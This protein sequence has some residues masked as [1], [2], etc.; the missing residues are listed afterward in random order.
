MF[1]KILADFLVFTRLY[2]YHLTVFKF[3]EIV[4]VCVNTD[5]RHI[6]PVLFTQRVTD[7]GSDPASYAAN[8]Q[9]HGWNLIHAH[10]NSILSLKLTNSDKGFPEC[11]LLLCRHNDS[12]LF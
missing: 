5:N 9:N 8:S 12:I 6:L 3:C 10:N 2:E 11:L 7:S 4:D 1:L